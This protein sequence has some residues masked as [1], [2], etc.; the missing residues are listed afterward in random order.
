M[1]VPDRQRVRLSAA[2]RGFVLVALVAPVLWSRDTAA[3]VALVAIGFVWVVA[4]TIET[5]PG[6]SLLLAST[7]GAAAVGTVCALALHTSLAVLGA[8]AV[9]PFTAGVHRALRGVALSL[10]AQ[11]IA[12]VVVTFALY[13]GLTSEQGLGVFTWSVTSLGLG[14]IGAFLHAALKRE[15]DP[16]AP[17]RYAQSLIRQLI[18]LSGGLS[19]GLDP[20]PLGGV[21]LSTVRDDLPTEA[22]VLYIPRGESLT[23]L[24]SKT[25]P[26]HDL[27]ACDDLACEAWALGRPVVAGHTFALPLVTAS[28][29]TAVVAGILSDR[30]DLRA[31][32]LEERLATMGERLAPG[33]VHLDTALLFTAFRDAATADERRRLAREMHDGVAQDIASLGYLVDAL[34]AD[35][36]SPR[37]AERIDQLRGRISTV[38]AEVRQSL[39]TLRTEVGSSA[40]LGTAIGSVARNLTES[41]GVP[42]QVTLDERTSRLRPEVEAELFRIAQEAMTNAV[43]HAHAT[44]IDVQCRVHAPEVTIT[45]SD[46]GRGLQESRTDSHGLEIMRERALLVGARLTVSDRPT[47]GTVVDVRIRGRDTADTGNTGEQ[48]P[49]GRVIP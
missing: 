45:V 12:V 9:P 49:D 25:E 5:R 43:R 3:L 35:P 31:L 38:V 36:A 32:R 46:D 29:T 23:P 8:L 7:L 13:G 19:S 26:T 40:S 11:L 28:G 20:V 1:N 48:V 18:D 16:L 41:S 10:S 37:Q 27:A 14:L 6:V 4:Q 2:A 33:V 15:P 21:L 30:L 22:V 39:V 24:V 47:G 17:H 44:S 34:A 42:I